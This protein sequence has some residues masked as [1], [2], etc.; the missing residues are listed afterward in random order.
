ME[1][2]EAM[3]Y[4]D[5]AMQLERKKGSRLQMQTKIYQY[6]SKYQIMD[7][8]PRN[9]SRTTA[10]RKL[11]AKNGDKNQVRRRYGVVD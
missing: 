8:D 5:N 9:H 11:E 4:T 1:V 10:I 2:Q 3:R 7:H 6:Q